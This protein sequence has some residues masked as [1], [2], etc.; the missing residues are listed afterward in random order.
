MKETNDELDLSYT[1][2]SGLVFNEEMEPRKKKKSE[3]YYP[4]LDLHFDAADNFVKKF[5]EPKLGEVIEMTIKARCTEVSRRK[6]RGQSNT[7][8]QIC[9]D[10]LSIVGDSVE[11][12]S[13][14]TET[15]EEE[16]E[17]KEKESNGEKY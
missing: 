3:P 14:E 10:V 15:K 13:E 12:A 9:F 8:S 11:E 16:E 1:P 2:P 6:L 4:R 17:A 7:D 5:G